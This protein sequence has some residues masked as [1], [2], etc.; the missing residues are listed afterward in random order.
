MS[1]QTYNSDLADITVEMG[2]VHP[3]PRPYSNITVKVQ[4]H[5]IKAPG[6]SEDELYNEA[7]DS[8]ARRFDEGVKEQIRNQ[9]KS[10]S[11]LPT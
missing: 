11:E 3:M 6:Q 4:E 9:R 8:L 1:S 10:E 2:A 5:R 7:F